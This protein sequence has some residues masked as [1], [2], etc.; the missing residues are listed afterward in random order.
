VSH[1]FCSSMTTLESHLIC[2][3]FCMAKNSSIVML[4]NSELVFSEDL[5]LQLRALG[6]IIFIN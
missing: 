5:F 2:L 3:A 1:S 4:S 6:S